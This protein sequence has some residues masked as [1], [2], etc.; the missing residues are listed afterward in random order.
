AAVSTLA[1]LPVQRRTAARGAGLRSAGESAVQSCL[2]LVGGLSE[3]LD[4]AGE[5]LDPRVDLAVAACGVAGVDP[6][7]DDRQ[8]PVAEGDVEV[9]LREVAAGALLVAAAQGVAVGEAGSQVG[10]L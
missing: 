8:L 1:A 2:G 10:R 3:P 9:E 7:E 6:L 5:V 4:H